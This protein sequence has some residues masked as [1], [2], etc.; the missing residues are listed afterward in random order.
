MIRALVERLP[1]MVTPRW[2]A[3]ACPAHRRQRRAGL[4]PGRARPGPGRP[5]DLRDRRPRG[6][7]L[8]RP[9]A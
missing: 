4:S 1:V 9:D 2:V 8:R 5:R 7:G 6:R 3:R